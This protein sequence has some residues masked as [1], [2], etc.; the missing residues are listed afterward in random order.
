MSEANLNET[1]KRVD[2]R[3]ARQRKVAELV[4]EAMKQPGVS[5]MM[6]V[7]GQWQQLDERMRTS[8]RATRPTQRIVLSNRSVP[9]LP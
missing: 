4:Q 1:T 5:A 2:D 8:E 6:K 3:T 9:A 7:Y